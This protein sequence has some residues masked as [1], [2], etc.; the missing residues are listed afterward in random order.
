MNYAEIFAERMTTA[1]EKKDIS[2]SVLQYKTKIP[3]S[4]LSGYMHARC[5]PKDEY[6]KRIADALGV[7][8][9]WLNGFDVPMHEEQAPT[10]VAGIRPITLKKFPMLGEIACGK[11]IFAN[12]EHETYI[13]ASAEI[14]ADFCLTARGDSMIDARIQDG[15]VVFIKQQPIVE[16]GEIA[17]VVIDGEATLKKWFFYPDKQKLVLNPANQNYEP[18]V[19]VGSELDTITCLGKA[20]CFMSN[21]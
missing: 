21:L 10:N 6:K 14:K 2:Q 1:M 9:N 16:N 3:K 19:Y 12:E 11:P 8:V 17:A 18:L 7:S 13:D 4:S 15:D 5:I 20:V